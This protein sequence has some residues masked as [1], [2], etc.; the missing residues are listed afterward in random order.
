M[1][2]NLDIYAAISV[3]SSTIIN[4]WDAEAMDSFMNHEEMVHF[5]SNVW[6][7]PKDME[8]Y[9]CN[10]WNSLLKFESEG[11]CKFAIQRSEETKF[12]VTYT[13][14]IWNSVLKIESEGKSTFAIQCVCRKP[15]CMVTYTCNF[16]NSLL[17]L[18]SE[19]RSTFAIQ[20][21]E[22]TKVYGNLHLQYMELKVK[23]EVL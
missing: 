12:M 16:W 3:S 15:K 10:I 20:R 7:K 9:T 23:V 6:R 21:L 11:R 19:G 17:K 18:E 4:T 5:L 2:H 1:A 13:C 14:N 22:E 8:T